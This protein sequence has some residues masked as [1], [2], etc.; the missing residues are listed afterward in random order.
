MQAAHYLLCAKLIGWEVKHWGFLAVEKEA[1]YPAHFHTLGE[2]ALEYSTRVIEATL[3][4]VAEA[5]ETKKYD[6][7]WGP[8]SV[9]HLPEYMANEEE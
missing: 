6:T 2:E 7:R 4:E 8:Y 9:H 3:R 5:R 1:P